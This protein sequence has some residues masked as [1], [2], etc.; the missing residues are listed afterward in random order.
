VPVDDLKWAIA[1][2]QGNKRLAQIQLF[3]NYYDGNQP[4]AFATAKFRSTFGHL[5]KD[6]ADNLCPA[7]VDS[8]SDRLK[9]Q[10]WKSS[11]RTSTKEVT[12]SDEPGIPNRV[13]L[14]VDDPI[15]D[16][17]DELWEDNK[18]GSRAATIHREALK[19]G[20]SYLLVWPGADMEAEFWP[21][22]ALEMVVDYDPNALGV[23]SRAAKIWW[24]PREKRWRLNVYLV[25]RIE[26]YITRQ[27]SSNGIPSN[28][29]Q[30]GPT[31]G[32]SGGSIVNNPYGRV[33]VFHFANKACYQDGYSELRDV[34]PVQDALNK[35]VMDMMIAMEFASF[36]QRYVIGMEVEVDEETGEPS[37][38]NVKQY[39]VD[40][41][42]TFGGT[43]DE[44]AV[45]QFDSTDLQQF[46]QVQDKF[47]AE[48]ARI[49]GTPLHYFLITTG[50]F[51]SGEAIKSAEGRFVGKIEDRQEDWGPIWADAMLFGMQ[52]E[53]VIPEDTELESLWK[54]ASPRSDSELAD[55]AVKKK[56]LGVSRFQT[57]KELG[58]DD[59]EIQTMLEEADAFAQAQ[60]V[61]SAIGK[62]PDVQAAATPGGQNG[63]G[64][65]GG[66]P[67]AVAAARE[68]ARQGRRSGPQ[69]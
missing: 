49:S 40:R 29:T 12:P 53:E 51:P 68:A 67:E 14:K 6:F 15:A 65:G 5:F 31:T 1:Q 24:L 42:L 37:D 9:I 45:G 19:T 10:G 23:I 36:K 13:W 22:T 34:V 54:D 38:Q 21:H 39:G 48:C 50:D 62:G 32:D 17:A 58:Y 28:H 26:K 2:F 56:T 60:A 59:E 55:T 46:L 63:T 33:P 47:R 44:V 64:A 25:D 20:N 30:W 41:L 7:V 8:L 4:L 52:M 3:A 35:A 43:K 18:M 11:A 57:L 69:S 16:A 27:Q 66:T 61:L